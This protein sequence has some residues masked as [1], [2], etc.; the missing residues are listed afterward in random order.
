MERVNTYI[1]DESHPDASQVPAGTISVCFR[2]RA[3]M[4]IDTAFLRAAISGSPGRREVTTL[5]I[6]WDSQLSTLWPAT[7][8]PN[9]EFVVVT[10]AHVLNMMDLL[11]VPRLRYLAVQT[12]KSS[13]RSLEV[14]RTLSLEHLRVRIETEA[15]MGDVGSCQGLKVLELWDWRA[16][17]LTKLYQVDVERLTVI[18]GDL[19]SCAG[20]NSS[21]LAGMSCL[22][23]TEL[24]SL[25][26][27]DTEVVR[28]ER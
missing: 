18:G 2:N 10:G 7:M 15:D 8:F 23:V 11:N 28:V 20:M 17:D 22:G 14:L 9:V 19:R 16:R 26:G 24:E 13:L 5:E 12:H 6:G 27:I 21:R 4:P 3:N 1:I 25:I